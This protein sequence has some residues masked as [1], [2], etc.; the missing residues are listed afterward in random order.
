ML[1]IEREDKLVFKIWTKYV[2]L[3]VALLLAG[4][5]AMIFLPVLDL[6]PAILVSLVVPPVTFAAMRAAYK[7]GRQSEKEV[8]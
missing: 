8:A 1:T 7:A 5:A 2:F 3:A 4:I 6:T